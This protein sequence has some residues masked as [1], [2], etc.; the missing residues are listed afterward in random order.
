MT[1]LL[2]IDA[3]SFFNL[4]S[5]TIS[6]TV[7]SVSLLILLSVADNPNPSLSYSWIIDGLPPITNTS[8]TQNF[9]G[10]NYTNPDL[11]E[12]TLQV[13][14]GI[15]DI[16][17]IETIQ[18]AGIGVLKTGVHYLMPSHY[19]KIHYPQYGLVKMMELR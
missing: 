7:H 10:Q 14:D 3:D 19:V 16:D 9:N 18:V 15:C 13:S 4:P 12:V 6:D 8:I 5:Y 11:I 17:I 2:N 1:T